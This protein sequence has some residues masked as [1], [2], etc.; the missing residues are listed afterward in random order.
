MLKKIHILVPVF[1]ISLFAVLYFIA[2]QYYPGG[3]QADVKSIG[4]SWQHNYW[5]NLLN[6]NAMN[7]QANPARPIAISAMI[8]LCFSLT[9]FWFN[10]PIWIQSSNIIAILIRSSGI[11]AM[12]IS[13]LCSQ[14]SIMI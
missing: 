5:C 12:G 3:S 13:L 2:T 6:E 1:G 14:Y 9:Y 10:L 4:F 11:L 7:G 8:I